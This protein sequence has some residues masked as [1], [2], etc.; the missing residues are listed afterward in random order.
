MLPTQ[1]CAPRHQ[2]GPTYPP[3][4]FLCLAEDAW[5]V[6]HGPV[7]MV[8][9]RRVSDSATAEVPGSMSPGCSP[10]CIF[11]RDF[12]HKGLARKKRH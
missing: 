12:N 8:V 9:M 1:A 4:P 11:D 3:P 10:E 2:A 6:I 5:W 7:A